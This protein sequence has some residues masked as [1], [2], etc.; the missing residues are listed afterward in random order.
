MFFTKKFIKLHNKLR[1]EGSGT[2]VMDAVNSFK[3]LFIDAD[4]YIKSQNDI[5]LISC[6]INIV[7][8]ILLVLILT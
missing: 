4:N 5:L 8:S 3:H 6:G 7:L 1:K 2:T